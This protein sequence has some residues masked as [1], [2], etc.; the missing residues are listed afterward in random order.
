MP[1]PKTLDQH[2]FKTWMPE[3]AYVLGYFAADG[4]MLKNSRGAHFIEFTSVDRILIEQV[5]N[6]AQSNHRVA[7]RTRRGND[8]IAYRL[9]LGSKEW[10]SDL[11]KLGFVQNKS[12]T[13]CFPNVPQEFVGDFVRGSFDGDGCAYF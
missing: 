3:M 9:Q 10:Y 5:Q 11:T 8:Q 7:V 12:K 2:F 1:V 4:S 13:L 6:A